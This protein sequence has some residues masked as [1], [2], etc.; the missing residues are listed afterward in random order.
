MPPTLSAEK[1][2]VFQEMIWRLMGNLQDSRWKDMLDAGTPLGH[3]IR[4]RYLRLATQTA[5]EPASLLVEAA[6]VG[7]FFRSVRPLAPRP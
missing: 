6:Q 4:E 5:D 3:W 7:L 1:Q 2:V